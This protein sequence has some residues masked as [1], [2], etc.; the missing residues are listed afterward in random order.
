MSAPW[1]ILAFFIILGFL[2]FIHELGHLVTAKMRGVKVLEF[3]LGFPPRII[4]FRRG[5]TEYSLNAI[6]LGGFCKMLGEEDP[7]EP[8]SLASKGAGTRLLVLSAGS[9]M[10]LLFPFILF[11]VIY[12][13]PRDV[14]VGGEGVQV[15]EVVV[16]SPAHAAGVKPGDEILSIDGE[17]V[18]NIEVLREIVAA[19]LGSEIDMV[20]ERD[21]EEIVLRMIPREDPPPGQGPLGVRIGPITERRSHPP[22]EAIYLGARHSAG[23]VI[24][25]GEGIAAAIAGEIP[26]APVGIIGIGQATTAVARAG[27]LNLLAW[28]AF[29]SINL[30]IFNLLPIPALDGGRIAFVLLEL[31]RRGKRVSPRVENM[32]HGVGFALLLALIVIISY[33][34]ILRIFRGE[35]FLP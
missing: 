34:D 20:V 17:E 21:L 33:H 30:G 10:M 18:R 5:E 26:F 2:I 12:M 24:M 14:V 32:V 28:A 16:D 4:G 3:G 31:L 6:P 7:S 1:A 11:P 25:L 9:L 8:R 27:I 29:L 22:W 23:M 35:G 13:V 19:R 15:T